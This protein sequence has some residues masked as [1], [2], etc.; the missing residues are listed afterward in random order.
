MGPAKSL[1]RVSQFGALQGHNGSFDAAPALPQGAAAITASNR[2]P[3]ANTSPSKHPRP[4]LPQ[5]P[6]QSAS[7]Q[8]HRVQP[9]DEI[10]R[11]RKREPQ[12]GTSSHKGNN[13]DRRKSRVDGLLKQRRQ[14]IHAEDGYRYVP[15][16]PDMPPMPDIGML[17]VSGS[18]QQQL[19]QAASI[20]DE[21]QSEHFDA[22]DCLSLL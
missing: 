1:R 17:P 15:G 21:L 16:A 14:S 9:S 20:D 19:S 12:P 10:P 3:G 11:A 22:D 5:P 13:V 7:T 18:R 6:D 2:V 4:N 8:K